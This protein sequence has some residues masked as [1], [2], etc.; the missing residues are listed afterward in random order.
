[1][2]PSTALATVVVDE[3]ARHGVTDA[4]LAPGSR[5][6]PLAMA[7]HAHPRL[8]VHVRLDE[9]SAAFLALGLAR[10][11]GRP[12]AVVCTSGTAAANLHPAVLEADAAAVP[13]LALT[14]DRP[15]ELRGTGANQTVDQLKLYGAAVRWFCEVG[16]PED[17]PG[18]VAAWRSVASRAV[19]E[20]AGATGGRPG[21]VHANLAFREPLVPTGSG[22]CQPLDG[23]AGGRPWTALAAR[24]R[25]PDEADVAWLARRAAGARGLLLAGDSEADPGALLALAEAAGWPLLA[26]PLS[27]ARQGPNAVA[28][29]DL[30][31]RSDPFWSAWRPDLVVTVGRVGLS[32]ALLARLDP[33]V[34]RVLVDGHG[35]WLD[36]TRSAS[37][38]VVADPGRYAEAV[39][40]RLD[41]PAER[42]WLDGWLQAD[43]VAR[44]AADAV[45]D[46]DDV[47][48]E[49]RTARDLAAGLAHGAL[50]VV[51]SSMPVRDLDAT[52]APRPGLRVLANRGASGIDGFVSTAIG[53][54]LAWDGPAAALVGDL[55]LLHD[56]NGLLP[57]GRRPDLPFVVV[58][59]DGGG[60]FSFLPQA[61]FPE[62]F[63][64]LF[65]TPHGVDLARLAAAF[66]VGH[67]RL[68]RA[69]ELGAA[70]D[71][72]RAA[73][74]LQLLEV[75]TGRRANVALHRRVVAA[76]LDALA[77][78]WPPASP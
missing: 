28:G 54:A 4:C 7:L 21:P 67:R 50:L 70:L 9:R 23:R 27:G 14:A 2:N 58:N 10:A 6:A 60:I 36:P 63:E 42:S 57:G 22:F 46:A 72:A 56:Q 55:S 47:P 77:R 33:S 5:S 13:L 69:G 52:M 11:S 34:D 41:R 64:A 37:R 48:S 74:G 39:A 18:S 19:A 45:L 62:P 53:A 61:G 17:R 8:R 3:L 49:P 40:A 24:P 25:P 51:A 26:D 1:M 75:R 31:A 78:R 59:N 16:A 35:A 30:L 76:A 20:A 15:P 71:A 73:G 44:A 43:R 66:G 29:Y 12:V 68:E 32:K 38:L 65:G